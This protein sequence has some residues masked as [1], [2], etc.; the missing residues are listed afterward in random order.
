M[1]K[2]LNEIQLLIYE[3]SAKKV[4]DNIEGAGKLFNII[5]ILVAG[6]YIGVSIITALSSSIL[7][8]LIVCIILDQLARL[9]ISAI[10]DIAFIIKIDDFISDIFDTLKLNGY[11]NIEVIEK[12]SLEA[13][14]VTVNQCIKQSEKEISEDRIKIK[15]LEAKCALSALKVYMKVCLSELYLYYIKLLSNK[16]IDCSKATSLEYILSHQEET[17]FNLILSK[18]TNRFIHTLEFLQQD[19]KV[20]KS[21][22]LEL[23]KQ[24]ARS[25]PPVSN[26]PQQSNRPPQSQSNQPGFKRFPQPGFKRPNFNRT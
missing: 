1:N 22:V 2:I 24:Q 3:V 23:I 17:P 20:F 8:F 4:V 9:S 18:I 19:T 16:G 11:N 7:H 26:I 12:K 13:R 15:I 21:E 5:P 25:V 10:K 14:N 6:S